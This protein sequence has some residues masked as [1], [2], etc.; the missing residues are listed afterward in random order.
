MPSS[1]L[2]S[3]WVKMPRPSWQASVHAERVTPKNLRIFGDQ[4]PQTLPLCDADLALMVTV[5]IYVFSEVC[6]FQN[7]INYQ[8][9]VHE[10][11]S[12]MRSFFLSLDT[13]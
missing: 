7:E 12:M 2:R 3:P 10:F 6:P 4:N 1:A 13:T 8:A 11:S 5:A 9:D